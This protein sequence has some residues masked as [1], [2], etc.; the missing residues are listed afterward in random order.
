ML[1]ISCQSKSSSFSF[2]IGI[3]MIS[4]GQC[5]KQ[6]NI[7]ISGGGATLPLDVYKVSIRGRISFCLSQ[8]FL[9]LT[10]ATEVCYSTQRMRDLLKKSVSNQSIHGQQFPFDSKL[11][12]VSSKLK[13]F[14]SPI[15]L[16]F[17][18]WVQCC[19]DQLATTILG[20]V[21]AILTWYFKGKVIC[22]SWLSC[23]NLSRQYSHFWLASH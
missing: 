20:R 9:C 1:F 5:D 14:Q 11:L 12:R 6:L 18:V 3:I 23:A 10:E 17:V 8:D 7:L 15:S 2:L 19:P 13:G 4:V 22:F 21:V 16:L